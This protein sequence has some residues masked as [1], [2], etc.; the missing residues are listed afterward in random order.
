[1]ASR[2]LPAT[3]SAL[4]LPDDSRLSRQDGHAHR[5]ESLLVLTSGLAVFSHM[6][7]A[8]ASVSWHNFFG[9]PLSGYVD[10]IEQAMPLIAFMGIA[11]AQRE[12]GHSRM[13]MIT[14]DLLVAFSVD[15]PVAAQPGVRGRISKGPW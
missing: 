14:I 9:Q 8:V 2:S 5:V 4:V 3:G 15:R 10:R 12:G 13:D 1:M 6:V 7:L 11:Y